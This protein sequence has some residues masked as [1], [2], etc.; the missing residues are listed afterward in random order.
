M[1][2]W[3][4][5]LRITPPQKPSL[6]KTGFRWSKERR[7]GDGFLGGAF[8]KKA[9]TPFSNP[10]RTE[11]IGFSL[12]ASFHGGCKG[13]PFVKGSPLAKAKDFFFLL[14][15]SLSNVLFPFQPYPCIPLAKDYSRILSY[16]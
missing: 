4:C 16:L 3:F 11:R 14:V 8:G 1:R 9:Y 7:N 13:E 12:L 15:R 6:H 5:A 2:P 10:F